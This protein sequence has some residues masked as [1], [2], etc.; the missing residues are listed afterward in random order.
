VRLPCPG[1]F[2]VHFVLIQGKGLS[3]QHLSFLRDGLCLFPITVGQGLHGSSCLWVGE[4]RR[5]PDLSSS[6]V[7]VVVIP[8]PV[9]GSL[10]RLLR[11]GL[12]LGCFRR[13][14]TPPF[15]PLQLATPR[16]DLAIPQSF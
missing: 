14:A 2:I 4:L 5:S 3:S 13:P 9:F 7:V 6:Q 10:N 11:F 16:I 1:L 8:H 12:G 15:L